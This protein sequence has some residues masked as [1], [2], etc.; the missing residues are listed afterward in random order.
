MVDIYGLQYVMDGKGNYYKKNEKG[1]LVIASGEEDATQFTFFEAN[2]M[3][4]GNTS[5]TYFTVPVEDRIQEDE[6]EM[7]MSE[8]HP[9]TKDEL[10]NNL[11]QLCYIASITDERMK[12]LNEELSEVDQKI[13]DVLHLFELYELTEEERLNAVEIVKKERQKR[14]DIKDEMICL[15]LYQTT[16]GT[17]ESMTE[18]K[19]IISSIKR[20]YYRVYKP[21][22]LT[23]LFEGMSDRKIDRVSYIDTRNAVSSIDTD[24]YEG[25]ILTMEYTRKETVYDGRE[26]DWLAFAKK[27][28][29]FYQNAPQYMINLQMDIE[30]IDEAIEEALAHIEDANYNVA[31][32]YKAFKEL[33]ELRNK[34]KEKQQE[35]NCLSLLTQGVDFT[36]MVDMYVNNISQA[37]DIIKEET[38]IQLLQVC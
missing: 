17:K 29:E 13:C 37:E 2:Q 9:I 22:Q 11:E 31:Q 26:N 10:I 1:R 7:D 24:T 35:L 15:E 16:F 34:R 38:K 28:L 25:G 3:I 23:E 18:A 20:M 4:G 36:Y 6:E 19:N 33:K 30:A 12:E 14:R 5:F 21:R 27:Q 32:G 8:K